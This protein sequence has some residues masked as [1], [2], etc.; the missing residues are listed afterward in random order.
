MKKQGC[1]LDEVAPH[2][3]WE[4][5]EDQEGGDFD[6]DSDSDLDSDDSEAGLGKSPV[7]HGATKSC[8]VP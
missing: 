4:L 6:S 7:G 1:R 2:L 5:G 8:E 3:L